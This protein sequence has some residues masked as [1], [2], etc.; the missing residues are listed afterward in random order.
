MSVEKAT[1]FSGN[2]QACLICGM[3]IVIVM[4]FIGTVD[5]LR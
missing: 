5:N 3:V 4:I 2:Q 1:H